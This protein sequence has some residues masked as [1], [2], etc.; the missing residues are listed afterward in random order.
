MK[1]NWDDWDARHYNGE[2]P[3]CPDCGQIVGHSEEVHEMLATREIRSSEE[4]KNQK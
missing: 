1:Y 2:L 4:Q 3:G